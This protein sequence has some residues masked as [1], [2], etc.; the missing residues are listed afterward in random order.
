ML[1]MRPKEQQIQRE[2]PEQVL[3]APELEGPVLLERAR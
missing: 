2:K 1:S 3:P